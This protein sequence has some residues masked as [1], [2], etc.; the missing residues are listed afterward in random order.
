MPDIARHQGMPGVFQVMRVKAK[1]TETCVVCHQDGA[2]RVWVSWGYMGDSFCAAKNGCLQE[3]LT[4]VSHEYEPRGPGNSHRGNQRKCEGTMRNA[5]PPASTVGIKDTWIILLL[6][7]L[8]E[9]S[10]SGF[11]ACI[12]LALEGVMNKWRQYSFLNIT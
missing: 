4:N 5:A 1:R 7:F 9:H 2:R 3:L 10:P 6:R 12:K 8:Q 11:I